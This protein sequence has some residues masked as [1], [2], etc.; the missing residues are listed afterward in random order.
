M[1]KYLMILILGL[2]GVTMLPSEPVQ[3]ATP[4]RIIL[5]RHHRHWH[6]HHHHHHRHHRK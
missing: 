5:V 1:R 2:F 3:G 6:R 4:S